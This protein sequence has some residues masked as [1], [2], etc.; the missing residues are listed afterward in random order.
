M[1]GGMNDQER[2]VKNYLKTNIY[3][4]VGVQYFF[5]INSTGT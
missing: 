2:G 5:E 3:P 1:R 4:T